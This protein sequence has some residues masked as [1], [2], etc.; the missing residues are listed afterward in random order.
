MGWPLR[1]QQSLP[2][3]PELGEFHLDAS[4]LEASSRLAGWHINLMRLLSEEMLSYFRLSNLTQEA[5]RSLGEYFFLFYPYFLGTLFVFSGKLFHTL[6]D[7]AEALTHAL[8]VHPLPLSAMEIMRRGRVIL[9]RRALP[10]SSSTPTGGASSANPPPKHVR[11]R[12]AVQPAL[13]A[14][15]TRPRTTR[16]P[17]SAARARPRAPRTARPIATTSPLENPPRSSYIPGLG[18][19]ARL[20][21]LG[22]RTGNVSFADPD[23]R[24][25]SQAARRAHATNERMS[26]S[27]PSPSRRR[28]RP[29]SDDS[30]SDDQPLSQ[31]RRRQAPRPTS[32]SGPSSVPSPP[33]NAAISLTHPQVT[34]PSFPS[35]A[36][37]PPTSSINRTESSSIP[38]AP[39]QHAQA[40]GASPSQ[41]AQADEIGLS[42]RPFH[43]PPTVPPPGPSSAPSD[44]T[45][46][47]SAPPNSA[48]GPSG[49]PPPIYR[50][51]C[52]TLPS[53][54]QLWD[55]TNIPTSSLTMKGRLATI[56]EESMRHMNSL[57]SLAQMD[58]FAELYT[59]ACAQSLIMDH[60]F[61]TTYHQKKMLQDRVAELETQLNDLAQASY[62]LRAE[63]KELTRRKNSLEVSL[64][65][66]NHELKDL[67][68]KISQADTVHQQNMDQQALEQQRAMDQLSQKLRAV[69]TL[70]RDQDQKLKSQ[71]VLLQSQ[72]SRLSSQATDL[73]TAK[74]ELA[75]A[76]ATTEGMSTALTIYREGE[77]DRCLQS[78]AA[79]L[80]SSEFYAQMGH[81]FSTSV[82]YGAGGALRQLH[83]QD[84]LKSLPP[85]EFL[86]HDRILKEI[87]DDIFDPFDIQ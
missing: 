63:I 18:L 50:K 46:E 66:S 42:E 38:P 61:H 64:A 22:G 70:V 83:E 80:R 60:S 54:E 7:A 14:R 33:P 9:E 74:N 26:Y 75:Q 55:Q 58:Q 31:R 39:S 2:S 69:E 17:Q 40:D 16:V 79:Y 73:A 85:P 57:S 27:V 47:P 45:T 10:F 21:G 76:R 37:N 43:I 84:Y 36:A 34:P 87:S 23:F 8:E 30:D 59:K 71:E 24:E 62:A 19:S 20:M 48:A 1:W 25:A 3:S 78:R 29:P 86:D 53:E 82:I 65:R 72:E 35:Q 49:P 77:N 52:T 13:L 44:E 56:W 68:K 6:P 4:Y 32:D 28:T 41:P 11:R 12:P 67:Q 81:H 51:Y 5:P 15:P